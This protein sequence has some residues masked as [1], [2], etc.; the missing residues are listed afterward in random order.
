MVTFYMFVLPALKKMMG[1]PYS[2][3]LTLA[4]TCSSELRKRAGRVEYQRGILSR[5]KND[6][7]LGHRYRVSKTGPQGSGVLRSMS[8]ANCFIILP[9]ESTGVK[10]GEQVQVLPFEAIT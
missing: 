3:P 2:E 4:A 8:D 9:M 7:V 10:P 1:N 6:N 5:E